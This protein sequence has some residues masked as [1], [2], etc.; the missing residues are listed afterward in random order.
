MNTNK[1]FTGRV[2]SVLLALLVCALWGSL[3]P[4]VKVG[5]AAFHINATEIPTIM[6]FAGLRFVVCGT[7]LSALYTAKEKRIVLPTK[8][9]MRPILLVALFVIILHYTFS[10]MALSIGEGSKSA[11]IKQ[12]GY[13]LLSCFSFLFVKGGKFSV[14]KLVCGLLGFLGI[15]VTNIN[16]GEFTFALGDLMLI[17]ASLCSVTSVIITKKAVQ[18]I[19]PLKLT[20]YSQLIGG[21]VMC[22]ASLLLGGKIKHFDLTAL[23]VF[24][25]ICTAS[26][27]SY[28][29]WNTLIKYNDL[30]KLSIIKFTEPLFAVVF[31]GILLSENIFRL[32][33]LFAC[34]ILF[35]AIMIDNGKIALPKI[36]EKS[37]K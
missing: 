13:L 14:K 19:N 31:S 23:F 5:Y 15:I 8:S 6:L 20:G 33:Y 29:L 28:A 37:K 21:V 35:S 30:A 11:I 27:A 26:V 32:N 16:G 34:L 17:I 24:A 2:S 22:V 1:I 10:Y 9:E 36:F 3:Y 7:V 18:S 4:L 25:C 12:V